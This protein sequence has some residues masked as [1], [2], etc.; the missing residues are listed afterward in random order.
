ME[1]AVLGAGN[2]GQATAAHLTLDGH[3]VRLFDRY[4]AVTEPFASTRL[5]TIRGA[6]DGTAEI[7]CVTNDIGEAV[8]GS[9]L[10][11]VTVPGFATEWVAEALAPMLVAG[12]VVI[13][14]PG[15]TGGALQARAVWSRLGVHANVT[16]AET[17]SLVYACRASAPGE[18]DV[19]AIKQSISIA[20][21]PADDLAP[22]YELFSQLYPQAKPVTSVLA[23]SL[24][25]MNAVIHPAVA[26]LNA[27][28]IERNTGGFDFYRDGITDHIGRLLLAVD[29]ERMAIAARLGVEHSS[30]ATW[31]QH[32]YGV[33]APSPRELFVR[34][35]A[36]VYQGIG[37]PD[38]LE[39]R[40]ISEDVPMALVPIEELGALA[41]VDTPAISSIIT[42]CSIVNDSDYRRTGRT[43]QRLGLG[44]FSLEQVV[45]YTAGDRVP[46]VA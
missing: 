16:V 13:L 22:A 20:A 2:G 21:L 40:Y 41:E 1:I 39:A 37:T 26:L 32:H 24:A 11:L 25:N 27:G 3:S 33:T 9:D 17:E 14:H 43:L 15:G 23:T 46:D 44:G 8:R 42:I 29:D 36:E 7:A 28:D 10:I 19:K 12:Q 45:S 35:A 18:P 4:P 34:L 5:I 30:Y 31:V 6:I 38:S